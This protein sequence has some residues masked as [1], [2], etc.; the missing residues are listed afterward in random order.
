MHTN[1][2]EL[3]VT[4]NFLNKVTRSVVHL[5][6]ILFSYFYFCSYTA[7]VGDEAPLLMSKN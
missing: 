7:R 4:N 6:N 1:S 3:A 5:K 2:S